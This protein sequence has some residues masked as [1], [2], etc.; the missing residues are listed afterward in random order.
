MLFKPV[1]LDTVEFREQIEEYKE[2]YHDVG[3][4]MERMQQ[5]VTRQEIVINYQTEQIARLNIKLEKYEDT[6]GTKESQINTLFSE[7][8]EINNKNKIENEKKDNKIKSL[9]SEIEEL[10]KQ[11][12]IEQEQRDSQ[13]EKLQSELKKNNINTKIE[14]ENKE[15][16]IKSLESLN[17]RSEIENVKKDREIQNIKSKLIEQN[18][19]LES[20]K[21]NISL[22]IRQTEISTAELNKKGTEVTSLRSDLKLK[23]TQ[24]SEF[25]NKIEKCSAESCLPFGNST[26]LHPIQIPGMAP[27]VAPCDSQIAGPG[28][29][30]M[31]RRIDGSVDFNRTWQD[32]KHG[33]GN[34]SGEFWLGLERLHKLTTSRRYELYVQ[35]VNMTDHVLNS[36]YDTFEIGSE[37]EQYEIKSLGKCTGP[38]YNSLRRHEGMKFTTLDRDNDEYNKLNLAV[39]YR[40]AWW[41]LSQYSQYR[42][43]IC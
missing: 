29:M 42:L 17:K 34:V 38:G 19:L 43:V 7:I 31:Q 12:K 16:K 23:D 11:N 36:R 3:E 14:T 2:K 35:V 27:F 25:K 15:I 24:I 1:L 37:D 5:N 13:L 21:N 39:E 26:D 22:L 30:I 32:Y 41:Y 18:N 10:R 8:K 40:G 33:F 20:C 28:W 9:E 6:V 4:K